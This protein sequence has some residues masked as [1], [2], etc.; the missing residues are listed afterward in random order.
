[1]GNHINS[2]RAMLRMLRKTFYAISFEIYVDYKLIIN[3][4]VSNNLIL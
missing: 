3:L 1:M 4:I 2:Y